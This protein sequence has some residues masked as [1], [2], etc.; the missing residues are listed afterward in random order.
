[1]TLP[2]FRAWVVSH[3]RVNQRPASRQRM[4][5]DERDREEETSVGGYI[6]LGVLSAWALYGAAMAR[7]DDDADA[8]EE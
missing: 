1:M 5:V 8:D 6:A 4:H 3:C 2:V 7:T